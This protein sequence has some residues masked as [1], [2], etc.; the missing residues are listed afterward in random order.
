MRSSLLAT[1]IATGLGL[2]A[3]TAAGNAHAAPPAVTAEQLAQLQAQIASLQAQVAELQAQNDAQSEVNVTQAKAIEATADTQKTVDGLKKLVN[4]TK[5]GGR[6]FFDATHVDQENNGKKTDA[7]GYGIDVKRFYLTVDH[8]FTDV[9]SANLTTDFQYLSAISNT[10]VFVKKAYL[11]GKFSDAFFFR[12]GA[13]DMAWIPFVEKYYGMR[14][15][16]NTLTDRLS[17]GTSSDWGVH[18]GGELSDSMFNYAVSVVNGRGYRN[19]SRSEGMDVE[20][21]FGFAPTQN[22]IIA[23]GGYNGKRGLDVES[24]NPPQTAERWNALAAY[25]SPKFRVGAEYFQAKNWAV[26]NVREDKADGYS[27]WASVTLTDGGITAF[28]RYDKAKLSK[29]IDPSLEDTYYNIGVEFPVVK[30]FKLATVYKNTHRE[31]STST[32]VKTNEFGVWGDVS[33]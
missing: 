30:G 13:A 28:G 21:R 4:D 3:L 18:A 15:V 25:A 23:V 31:N 29:D 22:T 6:I 7:T 5:I 20:G 16:E 19:P 32:D 1:A 2:T 33:F 14:Y 24:T 17:Y 26:T 11:Q 10:E 8:K 12:V 9:W 27:F